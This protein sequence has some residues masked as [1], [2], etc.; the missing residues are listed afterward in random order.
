[1]H[2]LKTLGVDF[3]TYSTLLASVLL[4]KLPQE[5]SRKTSDGGLD[6]LLMEVE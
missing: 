3:G 1:M 2:S 5:L 4:K 6:L